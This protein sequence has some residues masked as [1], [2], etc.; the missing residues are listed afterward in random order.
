MMQARL[1]DRIRR[2]MSAM[3]Q[4][5]PWL[6]GTRH[7]SL[8]ATAKKILSLKNEDDERLYTQ[9]RHELLKPMYDFEDEFS[10]EGLRADI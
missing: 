5:L 2:G 3:K 8:V 9:E 4:V 10:G 7:A 6:S 1:K